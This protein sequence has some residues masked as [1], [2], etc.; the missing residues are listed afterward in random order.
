MTAPI[1]TYPT[2]PVTV[3]VALL[4]LLDGVL[5]V[6]L[7]RRPNEPWA[8]HLALPGGFVHV[9]ADAGL[10]AAARRVLCD[11]L[12]V[13]PSYLEQLYTF[14]D[15]KRDPRGWTVS[16]SYVALLPYDMLASREDA[17]VVI[18]SVDALPWLAFDHGEIVAKAVERVRG[19][20][21]YSSL[22]GFLLPEEFTLQDLK[23]VY[24][25]V[26]GAGEIEASH[27]RRR[28]TDQ[29]IVEPVVGRKTASGA[30]RPAQLYRVA[31]PNLKMLERTL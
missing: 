28:I 4:T 19:K 26:L 16:V 9:D 12:G 17:A 20:A 3:D 14:G 27:F 7:M 29:G 13:R 2:P 6:L 5:S 10:E 18:A 11:K 30:H 31:G 23:T 1:E 21:T 22:P 24:E 15:N 8:G 25:N